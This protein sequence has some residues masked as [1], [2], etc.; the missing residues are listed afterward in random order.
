MKKGILY[1]IGANLS[2]GFLP[3]YW[4]ALKAVPPVEIL[5]HRILW[6]FIFLAVLM[7]LRKNWA[8]LREKLRRRR[9]L[10][11][12]LVSSGIIAVNWLIYIW[13]I[14][15]GHLVETSLGYFI[16]PLVNVLL[17]FVFLRERLN[18][19]QT[20][21]VILAGAGLLFLTWRYGGLPWIALALAFSF[22]FYGLIKKVG[23]LSA[24]E[25]LTFETA[26][27]SVP[28]LIFLA[29]LAAVGRG[30]FGHAAG[31]TTLLFLSGVVTACPLLLFAAAARRIPLSTVGF[32][33][34]ISPSLQF[35]LGVLV[36]RE[37]FDGT[38]LIGFIIIWAALAI[39][40]VDGVLAARRRNHLRAEA[41][42]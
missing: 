27:L 17:G 12:F 28:G 18:R 1:A 6:S 41:M 42:L 33:G 32:L 11:A 39:Y 30:A 37:P 31:R 21:A 5:A 16:N 24:V 29:S 9:T 40:S 19:L 13:A 3:V 36:Y 20:V 14:N 23:A 25:G 38:R 35:I 4:K 8:A 22:G 7:T 2:W 15:T 26:V 34:Y 10:A